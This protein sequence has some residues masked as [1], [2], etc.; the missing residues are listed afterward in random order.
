MLAHPWRLVI[1]LEHTP[2]CPMCG[3]ILEPHN[4]GTYRSVAY[5]QVC[6]TRSRNTNWPEPYDFTKVFSPPDLIHVC[7]IAWY[8][9]RDNRQEPAV[10]RRERLDRELPTID[11]G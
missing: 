2:I 1:C 6:A 10:P 9:P 5:C 4:V 11:E 3:D 8:H 7:G